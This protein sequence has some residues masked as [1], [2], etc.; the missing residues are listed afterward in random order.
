MGRKLKVY[1]GYDSRDVRIAGARLF[2][3]EACVRERRSSSAEA[4]KPA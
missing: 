1:V 2:A 3:A 4:G